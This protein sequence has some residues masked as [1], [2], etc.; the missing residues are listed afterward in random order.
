MVE[1]MLDLIRCL[2]S[3]LGPYISAGSDIVFNLL[4]KVLSCR[5]SQLTML[6]GWNARSRLLMVESIDKDKVNPA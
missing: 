5:P 4:L 6:K 2:I 1:P 3:D